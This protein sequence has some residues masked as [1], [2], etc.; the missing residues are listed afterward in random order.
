MRFI[1]LI[2]ASILIPGN[3][4]IEST[5]KYEKSNIRFLIKIKKGP[6]HIKDLKHVDLLITN[7]GNSPVFVPEFLN[8]GESFNDPETDLI[9][10]IKRKETLFSQYRIVTQDLEFSLIE[11]DR[12]L[13][14]IYPNKTLEIEEG[15]QIMDSLRRAGRY[16]LQAKV[17]FK[18]DFDTIELE[19]NRIK[20]RIIE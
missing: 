1:Y 17:K 2:I 7:K 11:K 6:I 13:L 19:S 16:M 8:L 18:N 4:P 5:T 14:T 9:F 15:I 10:N 3:L 20:F 12:N